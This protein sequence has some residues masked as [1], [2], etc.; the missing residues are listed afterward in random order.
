MNLAADKSETSW[1][2][3]FTTA[4]ITWAI[5][6]VAVLA[7]SMPRVGV[8]LEFDRELIAQGELWRAFT[9][10]FAHWN[11]DHLLWDLSAFLLLGTICERQSRTR[12]VQCVVGTIVAT[13]LLM[14]AFLPEIPTYRG[15]SGIDTGLF[16]M[17]GVSILLDARR[18]NDRQTQWAT[19]LLASGLL[20][21]LIYE[22]TTCATIFVNHSEASFIPIAAA[23]L[24]GAI[25]GIAVGFGERVAGESLTASSGSARPG[26]ARQMR[27]SI[28]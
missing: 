2:A 24:L 17:L 1:L 23:H 7:T 14:Y 3:V 21:K 12:F 16:T 4:P 22:I 10:H 25:I 26:I 28:S 11:F 13:S 8:L 18:D 19:A 6:V 27:R 20:G 9:G 5:A 15:L